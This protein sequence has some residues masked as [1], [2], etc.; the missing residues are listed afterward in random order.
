MSQKYWTKQNRSGHLDQTQRLIL[1]VNARQVDNDRVTLT[2][3]FRLRDSERV[4]TLANTLY[5]K[6]EA[7]GVVLANWFLGDRNSTLQ[8]ETKG[9][10]VAS[11][12][13]SGQRSEYNH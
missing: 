13:V 9:R 11:D 3:N 10:F 12:E 1:V 4:H 5:S 8:V 7:D 2:D 6:I